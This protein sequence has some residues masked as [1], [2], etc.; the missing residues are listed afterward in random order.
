M[1]DSCRVRMP[2]DKKKAIVYA[3]GWCAHGPK[4][5][6]VDTQQQSSLVAEEM[7]KDLESRQSTGKI[8]FSSNFDC[9]R[10]RS[11]RSVA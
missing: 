7:V 4:G 3:A 2:L 6:I 11:K 5:V 10:R 8:T 1:A 9:F